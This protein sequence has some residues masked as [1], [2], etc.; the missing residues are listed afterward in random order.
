VISSTN[1]LWQRADAMKAF[2]E[3]LVKLGYQAEDG[4]G[5]Q[6]KSDHRQVPQPSQDAPA[7]TRDEAKGLTEITPCFR[8]RQDFGLRGN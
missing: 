4:I 7:K 8:S 3:K 2:D 5:K 1:L 6:K